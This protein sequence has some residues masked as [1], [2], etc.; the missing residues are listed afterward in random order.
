[1]FGKDQESRRVE[2]A[3]EVDQNGY[4]WTNSAAT[5]RVQALADGPG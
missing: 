1:M 3:L 2:K 5:L 4:E